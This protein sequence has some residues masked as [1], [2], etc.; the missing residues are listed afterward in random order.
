VLTAMS[1]QQELQQLREELQ[2]LR[3]RLNEINRRLEQLSN[4]VG[5]VPPRGEPE[6]P[7]QGTWPTTPSQVIVTPPVI[8]QRTPPPIVGQP[9]TLS[10]LPSSAA[11][12]APALQSPQPLPPASKESFEVRLGTYWLPRIGIALLLT[13]MVF[14]AAYITPRL[15]VPYK[16]ALGYLACLVLGV[17]GI[18][19][20]RKMPQFARVLLAG[21][22][23]LAYF[24]TYA[25]HFVDAFRVIQSPTLAIAMLSV[26]VLFIIGVAQER[27]SPTLGGMALFFGYY[28]S[29][30]SGVTTFTLASNA[31]LALAAIFFLARNRWVT[32]S[33]GAVLATYLTYMLWVWKFAGW[34]DIRHLVFD[35]GYLGAEDFRLRAAFLSLYWL[36][37]VTGG[38]MIRGRASQSEAARQE[39][40]PPEESEELEPAERNGLLT[41]NNVF[42]FILFS[43][44]MHHAYPERQWAFQFCFGGA[45][46]IAS[47]LAG[48]RIA[49]GRS[50]M[51]ALFVQGLL[52]ATLG[53]VS[54][55]KGVRLVAVL[56]VESVFL[57]M[58]ARW[59]GSR[60]IAWIGRA[61]FAAAAAY[62]WDKYD[63]WDAPMRYGVWFAAAVGFVCARMERSLFVGAPFQARPEDGTAQTDEDRARKGA[64]TISL[65]ALYF[66]FLATALG[67]TAARDQFTASQMPWV[68][69]L[70]AI[71][72]AL[73]G[74][75]L[76]T[77]EIPW[78]AY[79]PLAWAHASF[80]LALFRDREWALTPSLA[81]IAVT[82]AFGVIAWGRARAKGDDAQASSELLPYAF[83][84]MVVAIL[85]TLNQAPERWQLTLFAAETLILVIAA[86]LAS[87]RTFGWLA[88]ATM[89]IGAY[90]YVTASRSLFAH[91]PA[92]WANFLVAA[93]LLIVGERVNH[94]CGPLPRSGAWMV[95]VVTLVAL[96]A[97]RRLVGG[98]YLTVSWAV[99][100]FV[101][102]AF[103]FAIKGRYYRIGGLVALGFSLLRAVFHDMARVETVY[104]ILSFIG[105]GVILLVLAFLYA[106]NREKIAKWL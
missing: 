49:S 15:S 50:I 65:S 42:F 72:V 96:Y 61:T 79:L 10:G 32:I 1:D 12:E 6:A 14:F 43:L 91:A 53:L 68:W 86:A 35:A 89:L 29:V 51:D 25:A 90:G 76:R 48:P 94:R 69:T 23:A 19:L 95:A 8:S 105:L 80:Y 52:V 98:A 26:I 77:R 39:P 71:V 66:A 18:G 62:A 22:L 83:L 4:L 2:Q 64:P 21:S 30:V 11:G 37:F 88:L 70:G 102:L 28:T 31:V 78:A 93:L 47:A 33:Y 101:L 57:L 87:E 97:L 100:G 75:L 5:R 17:L 20:D 67:M 16:V 55:F 81:L 36:V 82:F 103:G 7:R 40:R 60:W 45:L 85:V 92:P 56:A 44:L 84:A 106:K 99:L 38:L 74:G 41:L 34:G 3:Q 59:M 104:R 73:V 13:G 54:Y 24:V 46:L 27:R 58:L 9:R 63:D